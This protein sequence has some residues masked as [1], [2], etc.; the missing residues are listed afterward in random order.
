MRFKS[1][2][3]NEFR[4]WGLLLTMGGMMLMILGLAGVVFN[5]GPIG[6]MIA[7]VCMVIGMLSMMGSMAIYFWAGM[8]S[9]S[10][11]SLDCP[12]CGK[13]TKLL[14]KTDR[15][16]FCKTILTFDPQ[17]IPGENGNPDPLPQKNSPD[18]TEKNLQS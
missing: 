12:E 4:L 18:Q 3:V 14:G 6:K 7:V 15:C 2:K 9:T 16:M 11:V 1:S 8:L 5:W 17:Y 13:R 10:A